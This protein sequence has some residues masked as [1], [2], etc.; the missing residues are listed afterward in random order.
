[1]AQAE[2]EEV[3]KRYEN[4]RAKPMHKGRRPLT[5]EDINLLLDWIHQEKMEDMVI[6]K[7][8]RNRRINHPKRIDLHDEGYNYNRKN[9][10]PQR[11]FGTN[12]NF[13]DSLPKEAF[14]STR[15]EELDEDLSFIKSSRNSNQTDRY[16]K[17]YFRKVNNK[18][19]KEEV[20]SR[21]SKMT[22]S[23]HQKESIED[24]EA[25]TGKES[26]II[27][28]K[29]NMHNNVRLGFW[30]ARSLNNKYNELKRI[31]DDY[32]IF[33]VNETWMYKWTF[34][35]FNEYNII[36]NKNNRKD[37]KSFTTSGTD[38]NPKVN[39]SYGK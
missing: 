13:E 23:I 4:I 33:C 29:E 37:N 24:I 36:H 9:R 11:R 21:I 22:G 6:E 8:N 5:E 14:K 16:R 39:A 26:D 28:E 20:R 27:Q 7:I 12:V 31:V 32:D 2:E 3:N 38:R 35:K 25:N 18:E 10:Y 19:F 17:M 1:M 34:Q 30:N 15:T